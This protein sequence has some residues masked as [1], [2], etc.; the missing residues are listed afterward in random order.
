MKKFRNVFDAWLG[1]KVDEQIAAIDEIC[2]DLNINPKDWFN[3]KYINRK[4]GDCVGDDILTD[5]LQDFLFY[6]GK[7]FDSTM[8]KFLTPRGKNIYNEPIYDIFSEIFYS[9]NKF[10]FNKDDKKDLKKILKTFSISQKE[11]L[12]QDNVFSY[13][14]NKTK[15]KIFSKK[16]IRYL[17]IKTLNEY[18]G[19]IEE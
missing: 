3:N 16:E 7:R 13:I 10:Y 6:L 15:I 19:I 9:K 12:M 17:K 2:S 8:Y 1:K 14:I 18:N 5:L 4:I 11:E